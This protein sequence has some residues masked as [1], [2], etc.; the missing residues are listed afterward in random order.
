MEA[1]KRNWR[2]W[3]EGGFALTILIFQLLAMTFVIVP[4]IIHR[5]VFLS[6]IILMTFLKPV[7]NRWEKYFNLAAVPI[8]FTQIIYVL[9]HSERI[10]TRI[11]FIDEPTQM[12]LFLGILLILIVLEATRRLAGMAL[13]LIVLFFIAYGFLGPWMP[14]PLAHRGFAVDNFIDTQVLSGAGIFGIPIGAVISYVFYFIVFTAFLEKSGGGQLF[15]DAALSVAGWTRGGP[16]KAAVIASAA[17]GTISGS[18]VANVVGSGAFT[19]PLMKKTG[20]PPHVAGAVEAAASTGG[21]LMPPIMGAAAFIMA[22]VTGIPYT[23]IALA[24]AAPA[25]LYFLSIFFQIDFY[26]QKV[27]LKGLSKHELPNLAGSVKRYGHTMIPLVALV[28]YM[29]IGNSLMYAGL[30]STIL[31]ILLSFLRKET[32]MWPMKCLEALRMGMRTMPL[33]AIPCAAAGIIIG[34][35]T[36]SGLGLLFSNFFLSIASG[37]ILL[38]FVV[39]M[40]VCIIL[41]M[42]MPTV[43]AYIIV[44]VL[45]VPSVVQLGVPVL[46]AHMF[47]FYFALLSFVTPPVALAAYAAAGIAD[48]NST[49]TGVQAFKLTL[50]GFIIPYVFIGDPALLLVGSIPW[51]VWCIFTTTLGIYVLGGSVTGWFFMKATPAERVVGIVS[52]VLLVIPTVYTDYTGIVLCILLLV[53][54]YVKAKKLKAKPQELTGLAAH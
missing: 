30:K 7:Q 1:F 21:Q 18:A 5:I 37:S 43:S 24:A 54:N 42:G 45:M 27:G 4:V 51:I 49:D 29:A 31:L 20:F 35:V 6:L 10:S 13:M 53:Y 28:Y 9:F 36:S 52:S 16:A 17:M 44:I 32:R 40:V 3:A 38:T 12:D 19:I 2:L 34:V 39:I 15:I 50:G 14:G 26:A 33:I 48:A 23:Q 11:N 47:V 8:L 41:G 22:E 25:I 46:A